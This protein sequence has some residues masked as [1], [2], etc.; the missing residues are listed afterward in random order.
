MWGRKSG[1]NATFN[2][3][4][5]GLGWPWVREFVGFIIMFT[6]FPAQQD[7]VN[8]KHPI[9]SGVFFF[10]DYIA[11]STGRNETLLLAGTYQ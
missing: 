9:T 8:R 11:C 6:C 3:F 10:F 4:F 1:P 2:P 5:L 7:S